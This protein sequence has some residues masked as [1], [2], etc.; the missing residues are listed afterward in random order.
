MAPNIMQH[1][2]PK[3]QS[4]MISRSLNVSILMTHEALHGPLEFSQTVCIY[5]VH[6]GLNFAGWH[7]MVSESSRPKS[8]FH[9]S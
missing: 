3:A 8:T 2:G 1:L 4:F 5:I 9:I 7:D 6:Y